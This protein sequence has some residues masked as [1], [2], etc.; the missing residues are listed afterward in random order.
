MQTKYLL[1]SRSHIHIEILSKLEEEKLSLLIK[2]KK[3]RK[4][5]NITLKGEK[6]HAFP[7]GSG[8]RQEYNFSPFLFIILLD[9]LANVTKQK[10]EVKRKS[11]EN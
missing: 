9:V 3:S 6:I 10:K 5:T 1:K 7:L 8:T 11:I 4:K 2:K